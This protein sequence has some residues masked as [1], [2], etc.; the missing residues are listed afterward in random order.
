LSDSQG[1]TPATATLSLTIAL[2]PPPIITP[3][4]LPDGQIGVPYPATPL[5]VS[6]GQPPYTWTITAGSLPG[7]CS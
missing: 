3:I 6:G 7:A 2:P 1:T 4:T 5:Q